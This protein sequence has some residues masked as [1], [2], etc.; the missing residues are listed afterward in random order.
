MTNPFN[1]SRDSK[2][3]TSYGI[4]PHKLKKY[5]VTLTGGEEGHIP[6]DS[7]DGYVIYSPAAGGNYLISHA[8]NITAL[9]SP[10]AGVIQ[11]IDSTMNFG[12]FSIFDWPF[13]PANPGEKRIYIRALEALYMSIVVGSSR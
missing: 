7:D 2:G 12:H 11:T 10:L 1:L 4:S 3:V 13:D 5:G 9:P 8:T 6:L